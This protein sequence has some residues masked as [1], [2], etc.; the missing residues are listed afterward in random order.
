MPRSMSWVW[1][2]WIISLLSTSRFGGRMVEVLTNIRQVRRESPCAFRTHYFRHLSL[3]V[4]TVVKKK[5]C[6]GNIE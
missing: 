1:V 6:G 4:C 3:H 2:F 5:N